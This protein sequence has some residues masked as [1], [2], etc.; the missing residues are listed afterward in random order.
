VEPNEPLYPGDAGLLPADVRR[1]LAV[2]LS[3]PSLDGKRHPKLWTVLTQNQDTVRSR[4]SE[5]FLEL[6]LD[7]GL[8]VAFTR[9]VQNSELEIP[10]LL[11]RTPLT[12]LQSALLLHLRQLLS[13]AESRSERAVIS[14]AE[15]VE[16][17]RLY[18][19]PGNTDRAAFERHV[20][21]AIDRMKTISILGALRGTEDRYEI[22]PTLKLIVGAEEIAGLIRQY[23]ELRGKPPAE[24][25]PEH[26]GN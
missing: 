24:E 18:E 26:V 8:E 14:H 12:F 4:L 1:V 13:E 6:V 7:T 3:G 2:L 16:N 23:I 11:R 17:L 22:S 5:L 20:N 21:A 25:A 10:T 15:I 9:Q 19:V